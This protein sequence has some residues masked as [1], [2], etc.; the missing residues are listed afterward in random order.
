MQEPMI[1]KVLKDH[2]D[3][4]FKIDASINREAASAYG[5]MGVPFLAFIEEGKLVSARAGVQSETAIY[6]FLNGSKG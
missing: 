4:I 5:V 3:A 6:G 1:Q 2:P